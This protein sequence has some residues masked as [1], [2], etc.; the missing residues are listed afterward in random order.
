MGQAYVA[1]GESSGESIGF[2]VVPD[3]AHFELIAP[4]T[5]SW[6][7]IEASVQSLLAAS[8]E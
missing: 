5:Y 3:A 2:I 4:W 8:G 7:L 1:A 6:P